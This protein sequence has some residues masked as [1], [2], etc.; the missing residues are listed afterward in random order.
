MRI[1]LAIALAVSYFAGWL[2]AWFVVPALLALTILRAPTGRPSRRGGYVKPPASPGTKAGTIR[3]VSVMGPTGS[4]SSSYPPGGLSAD[5]VGRRA[6]RDP[7]R[8]TE[9]GWSTVGT[10][11][12]GA[13]GL[14]QAFAASIEPELAGIIMDAPNRYEHETAR[15]RRHAA[16]LRDSVCAVA[17]WPIQNESPPPCG[18][19]DTAA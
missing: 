4:I 2:P 12:V 9:R 3:G 15:T 14:R 17:T 10:A 7:S 19:N 1:T 18:C 5:W 11:A 8:L 6:L 16:I 13:N